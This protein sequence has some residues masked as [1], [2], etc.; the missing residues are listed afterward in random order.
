MLKTKKDFIPLILVVIAG[1]YYSFTALSSV[2]GFSLKQLVGLFL[3]TLA[4]VFFA[5]KLRIGVLVLGLFF[6]LGWF[7]VVSISNDNFTVSSG[8][9]AFETYIPFFNGH[10]VILIGT[11]LHFIM[12]GK[13]YFGI[14]TKKYWLDFLKGSVDE[15]IQL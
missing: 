1:L 10:P 12:S 4:V 13:H 8:I 11:I 14:G 3:L 5:I 7:G 15:N 2:S 9:N 6:I